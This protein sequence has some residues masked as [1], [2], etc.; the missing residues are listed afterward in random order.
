[1]S[2]VP[3]NG[4]SAR[5]ISGAFEQAAKPRRRARPKAGRRPAPFSLRLSAKERA[6]LEH[7]AG[8]TPLATYIKFRLFNH[9]PDL[10]SYR[11][12][13][14]ATDQRLIAQLLAAL[15]AS[16]SANNLNQL[17]KSANMGTL[18]VRPETEAELREA[19]AAVQSMRRDLVTALGLKGSGP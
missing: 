15:G 4:I 18:D 3:E 9:L 5:T 12:G 19:C 11:D 17:A 7:D 16:R 2:G 6:R 8:E 13:P 1:M 10:S 14:S